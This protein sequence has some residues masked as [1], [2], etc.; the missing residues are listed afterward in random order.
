[1]STTFGQKLR[2]NV[3][4]LISETTVGRLL[5]CVDD[6]ALVED[7]ASKVRGALVKSAVPGRLLRLTNHF[8]ANLPS[9]EKVGDVLRD[10]EEVVAVL[11]A[12]PEDPAVRQQL[13][14]GVGEIMSFARVGPP[15]L[16]A[17]G[18][19]PGMMPGSTAPS[20]ADIQVP[21]GAIGANRP[22]LAPLPLCGGDESFQTALPPSPTR[23]AAASSIPG[24]VEMFEEDLLELPAVKG[25]TSLATRLPRSSDWTVE[26][27]SPKLREYITTR[28]REAN[29][30]AAEPGNSFIAVTMRP[31]ARA[32]AVP[33]KA[34]HYSIARVDVI[35][36]E[37]LCDLRVQETRSRADHFRRCQ[38]VLNAL[39]DKGTP[40]TEY[41]K[42]LAPIQ[43]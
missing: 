5:V 14:G 40:V 38:S 13:A 11:V 24:P 28:F 22:S 30:S 41:A 36:F 2:L 32:G 15:R 8:G 19:S 9:D 7:L 39:V 20:L 21:T 18:T 12:E 33:N 34:I 3:V 29:A 35:E 23:P 16:E 37:R 4:A 43:L 26:G 27:L 10:A 1:M 25:G 6:E 42:K 17:S 31:R